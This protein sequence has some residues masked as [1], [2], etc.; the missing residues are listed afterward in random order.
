[1][2][3]RNDFR[4]IGTGPRF[5]PRTAARCRARLCHEESE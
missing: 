4:I 5:I 2:T 1:M 3:D